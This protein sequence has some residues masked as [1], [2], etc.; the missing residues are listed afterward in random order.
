MFLGI[1]P[2]ERLVTSFSHL[3]KIMNSAKHAGS[4]SHSDGS[5]VSNALPSLPIDV[6]P[7]SLCINAVCGPSKDTCRRYGEAVL[8][9]HQS[10][11]GYI[12]LSQTI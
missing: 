6:K 3:C 5:F 12:A 4:L 1:M 10:E 9:A 8:I 11:R 7:L 2:N